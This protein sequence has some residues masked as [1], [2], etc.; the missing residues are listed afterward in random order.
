[1]TVSINAIG[2]AVIC[3]FVMIVITLACLPLMTSISSYTPPAKRTSWAPPYD[4]GTLPNVKPTSSKVCLPGTL[5]YNGLV[6]CA[7]QTDCNSCSDLNVSLQ[8]VPVNNTNNQILNPE[9]K[10]LDP[11]A[12]IDLYRKADGTCSGRGTQK[13]CDDANAPPNCENY[14]CDCGT[15]Y[16]SANNDPT[17]C[18]VQVLQVPTPGSYCLPSYAN[19]CNPYTSNTILTNTGE[20]SE[21]ICECKYP[22]LG[23]FIQNNEGSDCT[24]P[25]ACGSLEA[26]AENSEIVQILAYK[27]DDPSCKLTSLGNNYEDWKYCN[28]YPNQM[29]SSNFSNTV[30]CNVPTVPFKVP[31]DSTTNFTQITVS[32]LADPK[33]HVS[34]YSN[35]CTVQLAYD[36]DTPLV[37]QVLRGSGDL[38]DPIQKR[39]WP[40]Y[41]D[42]LPSGMQRC[43]D[44]WSGDGTPSNPCTDGN[45]FKLS[46][47][48]ENEQWNGRFLSL[49]DLR[50]VGYPDSSPNAVACSVPSDCSANQAC[51]PAGICATECGAGCP[52]NLTCINDVCNKITDTSCPKAVGI[53]NTLGALDWKTVNSECRLPPSCIESQLTLQNVPR[54]LSST[55]NIFPITPT[56]NSSC[57]SV[58]APVCTCPITTNIKCSPDLKCTTGVCVETTLQPLIPCSSATPC[59]TGQLCSNG[60]CTTSSCKCGVAGE[61]YSCIDPASDNTCSSAK[62]TQQRLYDG[63]LDGPLVTDD[64]QPLGATCECNGYVLNAEGYRVPLIAGESILG[65]DDDFLWACVPDPCFVS[66]S[67]SRYDPESQKC[68]CNSDIFGSTYY[69]WNN[70]NALPTCQRDTCNPSGINSSIQR[71]CGSDDQCSENSVSCVENQ[72]YIWTSQTCSANSGNRECSGVVGGGGPDSVVCL[73]S[74]KDTYHCAFKDPNHKSCNRDRDCALGI[75]NKKTSLCT[76][77]CVCTGGT[78][79]YFTDAN[80]L[81]SACTNPCTFNPC[82]VNGACSS[83]IKTGQVKCTCTNGYSGDSCQYYTTCLGANSRC[84]ADSECCDGNC[85]LDWTNFDLHYRCLL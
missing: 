55:N 21:W 50:N 80:P 48:D 44:N 19:A 9:T 43:P 42:L 34:Q 14:W 81:H 23:L 4:P 61:G 31:I 3:V 58:K 10:E 83:D 24:V 27:N 73:Q 46:Y 26:Q 5:G 18:D 75:C 70:S 62:G 52:T 8:C 71:A 68:I 77:G 51:T 66:G 35:I 36:Q 53:F 63:A 25:I 13:S 7:R 47:L 57:S 49:Q 67:Q 64:N 28:S 30:P 37:T 22:E 54:S 69:S 82:G 39:V 2:I 15:D 76:G 45:G 1:M 38:N 17:N 41:P 79:A 40:P 74:S 12:K 29:I 56:S 85:S 33:C 84:S 6:T 59:A 78:D 16:K 11:P 60:F 20:G 32:P 72:C 65:N